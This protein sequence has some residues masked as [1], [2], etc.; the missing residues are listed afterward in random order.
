MGIKSWIMERRAAM[1]FASLV[2][3]WAFASLVGLCAMACTILLTADQTT[4]KKLDVQEACEHL[5]TFMHEGKRYYCA[6]WVRLPNA[7]LPL[8][9]ERAI[10]ED[11]THA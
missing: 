5:H 10:E 2:G 8:A 6:P 4:Y 1:A 3:L 11:T 9:P 7:E